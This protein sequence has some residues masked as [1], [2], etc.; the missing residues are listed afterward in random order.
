MLKIRQGLYLPRSILLSIWIVFYD[1]SS[2]PKLLEVSHRPH[3]ILPL[4]LRGG[5][6]PKKRIGEF[7]SWGAGGKQDGDFVEDIGA[8]R[9]LKDAPDPEMDK[10]AADDPY[11]KAADAE[12][13]QIP[14]YKSSKDPLNRMEILRNIEKVLFF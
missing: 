7:A 14:R 8:G 1:C 5:G 9:P 13:Y 11:G 4:H 6:I 3:F 12:N 10:W 2:T